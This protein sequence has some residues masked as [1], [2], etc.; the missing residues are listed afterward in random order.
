MESGAIYL[1]DGTDGK[2]KGITPLGGNIVTIGTTDSSKLKGLVSSQNRHSLFSLASEPN[3][4]YKLRIQS[5]ESRPGGAQSGGK[6]NL[7]KTLA[8]N[9][10]FPNPARTRLNIAYALPRQT[11]VELKLYDVAGKLVTTLAN[12]EQ[13]PGYYNVTW[14]RQD[15]KGR[16]C[17]CLRRWPHCSGWGTA[18]WPSCSPG[19]RT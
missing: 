11:R 1:T 6:V 18:P 2:L 5:D 15:T 17:A 13:K 7:P 14:N 12:G 9:Q 8:L 4:V 10:P 19:T 3:K 16:T